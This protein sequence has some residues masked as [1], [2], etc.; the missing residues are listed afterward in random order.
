MKG[1]HFFPFAPQCFQQFVGQKV[2]MFKI[3]L[4]HASDDTKVLRVGVQMPR[5]LSLNTVLIVLNNL[6]LA[7][8]SADWR[9]F[10]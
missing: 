7:C 9:H 10:V 5:F 8:L 6:L 2:K 1:L 4:I 3:P